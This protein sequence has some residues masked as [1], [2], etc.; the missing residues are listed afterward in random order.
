VVPRGGTGAVAR[1]EQGRGVTRLI[2]RRAKRVPLVRMPAA[3][4]LV[5]MWAGLSRPPRGNPVI[6]PARVGGRDDPTVDVD[7]RT[8]RVAAAVA[9][10]A[11]GSPDR[12]AAAVEVRAVAVPVVPPAREARDV[13][14]VGDDAIS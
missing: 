1:E 13:P 2:A 7:V 6:R 4:P 9:H 10:A 11:H 5:A 14:A 8:D 3:S 12:G